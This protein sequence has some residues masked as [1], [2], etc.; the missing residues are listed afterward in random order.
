MRG[1]AKELSGR[2]PIDE[3]KGGAEFFQRENSGSR[4]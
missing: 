2:N 4:K 1:S 3:K